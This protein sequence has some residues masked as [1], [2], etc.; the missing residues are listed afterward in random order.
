MSRNGI[1][2]SGAGY[3][4]DKSEWKKAEEEGIEKKVLKRLRLFGRPVTLKQLTERLNTDNPTPYS[5][6]QIH[7]VLVQ[8][9][10]K[11]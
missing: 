6:Q 1:K 3:E 11:N 8:L 2:P 10:K 4:L 9:I 7:L 5:E